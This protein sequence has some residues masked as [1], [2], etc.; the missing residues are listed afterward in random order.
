MTHELGES[1]RPHGRCG[2]VRDAVRDAVHVCEVEE[3]TDIINDIDQRN[4]ERRRKAV[5]LAW[6]G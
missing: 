2:T 1:R 5:I 6:W 4:R 3:R